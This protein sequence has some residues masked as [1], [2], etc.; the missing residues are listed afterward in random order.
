VI[1][2]AIFSTD[3]SGLAI[4]GD[5]YRPGVCIGNVVLVVG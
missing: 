1:T 2:H 4:A 3:R 5:E